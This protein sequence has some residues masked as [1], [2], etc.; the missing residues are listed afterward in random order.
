MFKYSIHNIFFFLLTVLC[1]FYAQAQGS[2]TEADPYIVDFD[3]NGYHQWASYTYGVAE[4][5]T[6]YKLTHDVYISYEDNTNLASPLY[7]DMYVSAGTVV[8]DLNGYCLKQIETSPYIYPEMFSINGGATLI[9]R[10]TGSDG[11]NGKIVGMNNIS[12]ACKNAVSVN[13][14]TFILEGGAI[15]NFKCA[16]GSEKRQGGAVVIGADGVFEMKGGAIRNCGFALDSDDIG[17]GVYVA[18]GGQMN[19]RGGI[20]SECTAHNGGAI[21][22]E[23]PTTADVAEPGLVMSGDAS[24]TNC[25]AT[26][27]GGGVYVDASETGRNKFIISED[28]SISGC[29]TSTMGCGVYSKG[30]VEMRGGI[31]RDNVPIKTYITDDSGLPDY[32]KEIILDDGYPLGGGICTEGRI[33]GAGTTLGNKADFT[34]TGGIIRGNVGGSGGG[35]MSYH[36]SSLSIE[37]GALIEANHAIGKGGPGNGGGIYVQSSDFTIS[38]GEIKGNYARRYGGGININASQGNAAIV[39]LTGNCKITGNYAGHGGG[40]SQ[41]SGDCAM[42]INS[43]GV[44]ITGNTARGIAAF[45]ESDGISLE[46]SDAYNCYGTGG[47]GGGLFIERGTLNI[48][49]GKIEGNNAGGDG[50]GISLRGVR[51]GGDIILNMTGGTISGNNQNPSLLGD[52]FGDGGGVDIHAKSGTVGTNYY[53]GYVNA[54]ISSGVIEN[55]NA[56][57]G[58]GVNIDTD[59]NCSATLTIGSGSSGNV[60]K[61]GNNNAT[62]N[63]GG[64]RLARGNISMLSGDIG[65][66]RATNGGGICLEK[67]SITISGAESNISNNIASDYGGGLYV[68][69][70]ESSGTQV[71]VTFSGGIFTGN[72]AANGGGMCVYGNINVE[73]SDVVLRSNTAKNGGGV[74]L[75]NGNE[76]TTSMTYTGGLITNNIASG[77]GM[78]E[79]AYDNDDSNSGVGGGVYMAENTSLTFS[80]EAGNPLGLYGNTAN[81]AADDIFANGIGTSLILPNVSAMS[82]QDYHVGAGELYWVEDYVTGDIGYQNGTKASGVDLEVGKIFR[83]RQALKELENIYKIDFGAAQSLVY[84]NTYVCLAIGYD[85]FPVT[86]IKKGLQVGESALFNVYYMKGS[87][88]KKYSTI[89]FPCLRPEQA[90]NGGVTVNMVLSSGYW[91]FEEDSNWSWKYTLNGSIL[92]YNGEVVSEMSDSG[93]HIASDELKEKIKFQYTFTN[94]PISTSVKADE[95]VKINILKLTAP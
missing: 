76:G 17:G 66:N 39:N 24:I 82:L 50:G 65:N 1:P 86:L 41:E 77:D 40:I 75:L 46:D 54:S 34:M 5:I 67:G 15:E 90:G 56:E 58:A 60:P 6:Y 78:I 36:N 11:S 80:I 84:D 37:G 73:A 70:K 32:S 68:V 25:T 9:I 19:F 2:G 57:N 88:W 13:S 18:A 95:A 93:V 7:R 29:K 31:I 64:I 55:N 44:E 74:Y 30:I 35:I 22:L 62:S 72:R 49:A 38:G 14:G 27:K 42:N 61:I 21:F 45:F 23:A 51:V 59:E 71:G 87:E 33:D 28:A 47:N 52:G 12:M 20:I 3:G 48:S 16:D 83:Y 26:Y 8:L 53:T 85:L 63:G 43:E 94:D 81:K 10:S 89:S 91:K 4:K 92:D 69:N 79:T